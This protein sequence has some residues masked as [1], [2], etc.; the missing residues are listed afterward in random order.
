MTLKETTAKAGGEV[1]SLFKKMLC[2]AK[3][4][5][6]LIFTCGLGAQSVYAIPESGNSHSVNVAQQSR[7]IV[8]EV[9]DTKGE[10][11]IGVNVAVKGQPVGTIAD[12]DGKFTLDIPTGNVTLVFSYIGYVSQE[13]KPSNTSMKVVLREDTQNLDEVVVVGYG[14]QKKSDLTG[15]ITKVDAEDFKTTP[16]TGVE[17]ALQG[18]AAGVQV[19]SFSGSPG[20]GTSV[21]IRGIGTVN[22]ANAPLYI[23]DGIPV[24]GINYLNPSD[25]SSIEILKDASATAIYGSRASNGVVLITT[26]RGSSDGEVTAT[27]VTFDMY[28]GVQNTINTPEMLDAS[29]F[30]ELNR[31]AYLS[32]PNSLHTDFRDPEKLLGVVEK[33]TGSRQ[34][35]NWWKET[36]QTGSVQNY[37][38][39]VS[40][41]NKK[42]SHLTSASYYKNEGVVKFSDFDRI[43]ARSNADLK[44]NDRIKLSTNIGITHE[45]RHKI[46]ENDLENGSV[47]N[48][49]LYDPTTPVWRGG[50]KGIPGWEDR[51]EGY[52]E[53]DVYTQFGTSKY[54]NKRQPYAQ[55]YRE[56]KN[57]EWTELKVVGNVV[58]DVKVMEWLTFRSNFGLDL[59]RRNN[60]DFTPR[61]YLDPDEKEGNNTVFNKNEN[62][63]NWV[64]ENTLNFNKKFGKHSL[65][66]VAGVTMERWSYKGFEAS[67]QGTPNNNEDQWV[68]ESATTNPGA[69]GWRRERSMLSYLARANYSYDDRYLLTASVRSDGSSKFLKENRWAT[70]PSASLGWRVSQEKFFTEWDQAF[71]SN[72]K[73]RVGWGQIGNQLPVGESDYLNKIKGDDA[74]KYIFGANKDQ[75]IGYAVDGIG[76]PQI[77]WETSEQTNFGLDLGFF[78]GKLTATMDY[79]VKNT[80]DML[81]RVPLPMYLGYNNDPWANQGSVRNSGFEM[82]LDWQDKIGEVTYGISGN[83]TSIKNE[84]TSLGDG[85]PMPGG[86]E[87]IG[88]VSLT[89]EGWPIGTFYGWNMIGVFQNQEQVDKSHMKDL[90]ARPGDLIFE[91]VDGDGELTDDDRVNLGSPF[92]SL[93]YGFTLNAAYKGFDLTAFFQGVAGNKI[94]RMLKYYSHQKS[95]YFNS[96]SD[97][98]D[99]AWRAPGTLGADDPGNASNT[100]YQIS[101]DPRLNTKASSYYVESGAYLRLKN[102]QIGYT[103]PD[104]WMSKAKISKLRVYV[105]AQ[106]LFTITQYGGLDPE[107]AGNDNDDPTN[108][109]IDRSHYPQPRTFMAGLNLAF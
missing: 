75:F 88:D 26:K 23:V 78:G 106:N 8:G 109:G 50:Y 54:S 67:K 36:T 59:S 102:I 37:N 31:R 43:T 7:K 34:G 61:Y 84:V 52:D 53:N 19:A 76:N 74:M 30:I 66:A 89:K 60:N 95:G 22:N 32:D 77:Q 33:V 99:V 42:I 82:Q 85:R 98:L 86:N 97:I 63:N 108:Y 12:M 24:G 57:K 45:R 100:E 83:L 107:L 3:V 81:I 65:S 13:L 21:R 29:G 90:S 68:L 9:V 39:S 71:W 17:S 46:A 27:S 35:T 72:L 105:G 80:R 70:F 58:L 87:R 4:A 94:F 38:V 11:L 51:L 101:A 25:I 96:P 92:P 48:A 44:V 15:S 104:R 73:V 47:F 62:D 18:R 55:S 2:P 5:G 6:L 91:D 16:V 64:W 20:A 14:T 40:G 93:M 69:T 28:Y 56:G 1:P 103:F 79:F 41:G 49:L 10:P